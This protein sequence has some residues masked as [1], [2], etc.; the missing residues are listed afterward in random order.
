MITDL[1]PKA[2]LDRMQNDLIASAVIA[3]RKNDKVATGKT[4]QS[5]RGETKRTKEG[6]DIYIYGAG[7]LKYIIEGKPANTK[8]P[9]RK[10]GNTFELLGSLK[11]WKN[12]RGFQGSDFILARAIAR[13]KREPIDISGQTLEIYESNYASKNLSPLLS[14]SAS[15]LGKQISKNING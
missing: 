4:V 2:V 6:I 5:I 14:F 1:I 8:L 11:D 3:L 10:V 15:Q 13:N 7:G 9:V 12:I